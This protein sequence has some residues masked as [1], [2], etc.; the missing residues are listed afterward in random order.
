LSI[1]WRNLDTNG[2]NL[3]D[4]NLSDLGSGISLVGTG[5]FDIQESVSSWSFM[6]WLGW[7][8]TFAH[9]EESLDGIVK[10]LVKLVLFLLKPFLV[11]FRYIL[12]LRRL[13][14]FC[15]NIKVTYL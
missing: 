6:G 8:G 15:Y 1:G 2:L 13:T 4:W 5:S 7:L 11:K 12:D 10:L 3:I 14:Q 9:L